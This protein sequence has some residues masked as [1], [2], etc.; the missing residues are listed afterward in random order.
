MNIN[1]GKKNKISIL[2]IILLLIAIALVGFIIMGCWHKTETEKALELI[3]KAG[4]VDQIN[5]EARQIF[6]GMAADPQDVVFLYDSD[7]KKYPVIASLGNSVHLYSSAGSV[8]PDHISVRYGT[9]RNTRFLHIFDPDGPLP[10]DVR[11]PS[12]FVEIAPNILILKE[13]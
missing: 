3:E 1:E 7:M 4:G 5:Q 11:D 13:K 2:V 9:H 10:P 6:A 12:L 8:L